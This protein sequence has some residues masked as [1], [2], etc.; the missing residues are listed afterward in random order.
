[1]TQKPPP[2]A[3]ARRFARHSAM[4]AIYQWQIA[5]TPENEVITLYKQIHPMHS[6][7]DK[8]YFTELVTG[9]IQHSQQL[10]SLI[11]PYL[12]N[13]SYHLGEVEKA[14]IRVGTYELFFLSKKVDA[15]VVISEAVMCAKSFTADKSYT[16]VNGILDNINRQLCT[17]DNHLI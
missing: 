6:Q 15:A 1:M 3:I 17:K 11:A 8:S 12:K 14:I 7:T 5:H 13:D 9:V 10:D 2:L 4:Q 16:F